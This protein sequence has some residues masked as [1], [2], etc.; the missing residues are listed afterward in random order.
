[1]SERP[2]ETLLMKTIWAG[3]AVIG[4]ALLAITLSE[5]AELAGWGADARAIVQIVLSAAPALLIYYTARQV[6]TF[7]PYMSEEDYGEGTQNV[8]ELLTLGFMGLLVLFTGLPAASALRDTQL[9]IGVG[10]LLSCG[11]GLLAPAIASR[12]GLLRTEAT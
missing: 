12:I 11:V 7:L 6:L 8:L 2:D 4:L 9:F 5:V 10:L 3:S 1:M